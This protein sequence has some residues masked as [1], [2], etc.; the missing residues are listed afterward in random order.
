MAR[1]LLLVGALFASVVVALAL[2]DRSPAIQ[3]VA[4][5]VICNGQQR[6]TIKT[7]SDPAAGQVKLA[8]EKIERISV[9]ELRKMRKPPNAPPGRIAPTET[10]VYEVTAELVEA[11]WVWD[12][13]PGTDDNDR[14]DRDIHLVIAEPGHGR[15]KM[16]VEFPDPACVGAVPA[17]KKMIRD[18]R[19]AFLAC[20]GLMPSSD[21]PFHLFAG[22]AKA[23]INGVG[24]FDRP[25]AHGAAPS[26]IEL[27][28]VLAFAS[29]VCG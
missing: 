14:G 19:N 18:A 21:K 9:T 1:R 22:H 3:P 8:P 12:P 4:A 16:I 5:N 11:R 7:L 13:R 29:S 17:L 23:T 24:F 26:G 28:P 27:H 15:R 2:T 20:R 10:T 25:H 6:W